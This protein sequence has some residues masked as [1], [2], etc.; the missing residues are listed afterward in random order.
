MKIYDFRFTIYERVAS[1][2]GARGRFAAGRQ[3]PNPLLIV[4]SSF[5]TACT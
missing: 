5:G 3:N 2:A 4:Q 1:L